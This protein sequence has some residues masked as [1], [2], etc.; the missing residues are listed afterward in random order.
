M[1]GYRALWLLVLLPF[2]ASCASEQ[3][4]AYG[5]VPGEVKNAAR[6]GCV[7]LDYSEHKWQEKK[8]PENKSRARETEICGELFSKAKDLNKGL[9]VTSGPKA[10]E[11]VLPGTE[12][13]KFPQNV[14]ALVEMRQGRGSGDG[15]FKYLAAV[16]ITTTDGQDAAHIEPG[17][18]G[19]GGG[20]VM[21]LGMENY[22]LETSSSRV[23][24]VDL[25]ANRRINSIDSYRTD[26]DGWV[27]SVGV[28][29]APPFVI[30]FV[31]PP[32]PVNAGTRAKTLESLRER[33][34]EG[35]K[36]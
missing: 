32:I 5:E 26:K 24:F 7:L 11:T 19:S 6:I 13:G 28:C 18:S 25:E 12:A 9:S 8:P 31:T 10:W 2:C 21:A 22:N 23:F 29:V 3:P 15:D 4:R 33:I 14:D 30:P 27:V 34:A 36:P 1:A 17:V 16:L 35:F 20:G